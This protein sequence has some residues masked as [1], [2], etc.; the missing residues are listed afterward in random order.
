[1]LITIVFFLLTCYILL[2]LAGWFLA[3][4]LIFQPQPSSYQ[5][6][7]RIIKVRVNKSMT[8][9]AVYLSVPS[10]QYTILYS[11][12]NAE[13]LGELLPY[14][15]Q[16]KQINVSVFAYDYE[17]YGTSDGKPSEANSY[18]DINAAYNYMIHDLKIPAGNIIVFGRSVGGG[19][20][21]Y[22]AAKQQV[23]A[24]ILEST[25]VSAFRVLTKVPLLPFD[26]FNNLSR[27]SKINCPL[28]VVHGKMDR[29]VA[30]WHG[31][32]LYEKAKKPKQ[33]FWLEDAGHNDVAVIGGES[34]WHAIREFIQTLPAK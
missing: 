15:R 6:D 8:I 13:D 14:L 1:M 21:G 24:L 16:F 17:G 27:I 34:Y 31:E 29:V 23:A 5:D 10:A 3:E 12:G 30:F 22:L 11:H 18:N 4:K 7:S 2:I 9:S 20:A 26:R 28:L 33:K 25:F 32:K 19:P